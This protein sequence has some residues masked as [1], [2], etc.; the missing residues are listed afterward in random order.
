MKGRIAIRIYNHMLIK[1]CVM[2]SFYIFVDNIHIVDSIY[3]H[4]IALY[5]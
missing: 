5:I 4:Y 2:H 1:F 3:A